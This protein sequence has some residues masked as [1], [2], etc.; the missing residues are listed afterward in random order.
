MNTTNNIIDGVLEL[1]D[2]DYK[3]VL[4]DLNKDP[5]GE[6]EQFLSDI[7]IDEKTIKSYKG[8]DFWNDKNNDGQYWCD[9]SSELADSKVSIYYS[10]LWDNAKYY[11]EYTEQ[12]IGEGLCEGVTEITKYFAAGEY[13]FWSGFYNE[14]LRALEEITSE[15]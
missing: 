15:L 7:G 12:A 1:I 2:S 14:I 13:K 11:Q 4:L 9:L 8:N 3:H 10:D 5:S 6:V